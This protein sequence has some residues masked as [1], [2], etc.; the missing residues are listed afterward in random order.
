VTRHDLLTTS[1]AADILRCSRQHVVDLCERGEL[2]CVRTSVHRRLLRREVET[3]ASPRLRPEAER[4]WRLH[5]AVAGKVAGNPEEA[6][7]L[8]RMNLAHM[9]QVHD[10]GSADAWL[11]QWEQVLD[12]GVAAVL[13]VLTSRAPL[14]VELR[15]NTPF[16]GVLTQ[17]ERRHVL[18]SVRREQLAAVAA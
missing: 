16:A 4:S 6:L 18:D 3:M 8:A 11:D 10:D 1:E 7:A 2:T 14:A 12:S 17:D 13:D 15:Q 9:R 5:I